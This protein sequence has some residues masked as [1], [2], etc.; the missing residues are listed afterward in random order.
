MLTITT[1]LA[2]GSP[3]LPTRDVGTAADASPYIRGYQQLG[4]LK[5][6]FYPIHPDKSP[7]VQGK[8]NRVATLDPDKIRYWVEHCH[9]HSFAARFLPRCPLLVIDTENPFKYADRLGPDG[10]MFLGSLLEDSDHNAAAM[11][12]GADGLGRLSSIPTRAEGA[13]DS[14]SGRALARHRHPR[15]RIKRHFAGKPHRRRRVSRAPVVRRVLDS[16]SAAVIRQT[17]P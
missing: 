16:R 10:E 2:G 4:G 3:E 13:S 5:V 14:P 6:G 15:S 8:L 17:N 7:A 9:H 1:G 11:P 12:N